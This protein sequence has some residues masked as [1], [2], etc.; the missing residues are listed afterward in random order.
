[1]GQELDTVMRNITVVTD[2]LSDQT[3]ILY[4][5]KEANKYTISVYAHTHGGPARAITV[6]NIMTLEDSELFSRIKH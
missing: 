4:Q 3:L 1:M 6:M 2:S 5:L